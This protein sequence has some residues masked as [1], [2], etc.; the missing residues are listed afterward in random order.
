[1]LCT[2]TPF[3]EFYGLATC[4]PVVLK[5]LGWLLMMQR[6]LQCVLQ[7]VAACVAVRCSALHCVAVSQYCSVLQFSVQGHNTYYAES[8][9]R[10]VTWFIHMG[11]VSLVRDMPHSYGTCLICKGHSYSCG[12]WLIQHDA[13]TRDTTHR[14]GTW[15]TET[16]HDSFEWDTTHTYRIWL[17]YTW[18]DS[19]ICYI[20]LTHTC[21]YSF[22]R[23]MT[24]LYV[25]WLIRNAWLI[26]SDTSSLTKKRKWDITHSHG[27]WLIHMGHDSWHIF[28]GVLAHIDKSWHT[29]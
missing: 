22:I 17:I 7:C 10:P 27:T 18:H 23:D 3:L 4:L 2:T 12:I 20:I 16:G 5:G 29:Y 9:V 26:F 19:F 24:Y 6:V 13:F 1:M 11:H 15:P 21:G 14:Y 8:P 25:A 28:E